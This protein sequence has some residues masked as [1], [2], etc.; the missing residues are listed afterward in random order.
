ML[1]LKSAKLLG[2][3]DLSNT[4]YAPKESI[5]ICPDD[6]KLDRISFRESIEELF[7][8]AIPLWATKMIIAGV[9]SLF[10]LYAG[11]YAWATQ[12]YATKQDV[13]EVKQMLPTINNKLDRVLEKIMKRP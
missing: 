9:L 7:K 6:C 3:S 12:T 2:N 5:L 11:M 8:R 4:T 1:D 10:V 13:C